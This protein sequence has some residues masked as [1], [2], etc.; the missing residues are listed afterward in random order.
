MTI[1][2]F[3]KSSA[4]AIMASQALGSPIPARNGMASMMMMPTLDLADLSVGLAYHQVNVDTGSSD[5][6]LPRKQVDEYHDAVYTNISGGFEITYYGGLKVEGDYVQGPVTVGGLTANM[7]YAIC[8]TDSIG[9]LG[10]GFPGL[11]RNAWKGNN[12]PNDTF[13][14]ALKN[15]GHINRAAFSMY[16]VDG[17]DSGVL[18]LGAID[19]S[20]YTGTLK[21]LPIIY[22]ETIRNSSKPIDYFIQ[23]DS[24]CVGNE[25][26]YDEPT[27][28]LVDSGSGIT[29]IP[30]GPFEKFVNLFGTNLTNDERGYMKGSCDEIRSHE[31]ETFTYRFGD[32]TMEV[33]LSAFIYGDYVEGSTTCF[34]T[35]QEANNGIF[36]I[37]NQFLLYT[38]VYF[39]QE[40][41]ELKIAPASFTSNN[42]TDIEVVPA[43]TGL[44]DPT[45]QTLSYPSASATAAAATIPTAIMTGTGCA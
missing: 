20:K 18:L 24:L 7:T 40:A 44:V 42:E 15:Q 28:A 39:D 10:L 9:F 14:F 11:E 6:W 27:M 41:Y 12:A 16:A 37:G 19:H 1:K 31:N 33:P 34:V 35:V 2:S 36:S 3:M 38:Y 45:T 29:L 26:V 23:L 30:P 17:I 32:Y 43:F 22:S 13:V 25:C 4:L 5:L 8:E 21:T